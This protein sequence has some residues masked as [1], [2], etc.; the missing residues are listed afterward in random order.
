[1][2]KTVAPTWGRGL[3]RQPGRGARPVQQ[4]A[5]KLPLAVAPATRWPG[6]VASV[7]RW[8]WKL[9]RGTPWRS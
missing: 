9:V 6:P 1:M 7:P 2:Q 4:V 8:P 3:V 5:V